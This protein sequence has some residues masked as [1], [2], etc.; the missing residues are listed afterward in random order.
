MIV[1]KIEKISCFS[2]RYLASE[3]SQVCFTSVESD[4]GRRAAGSCFLTLTNVCNNSRWFWPDIRGDRFGSFM[5]DVSKPKA[6]NAS[7]AARQ[8]LLS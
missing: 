8:I 5:Y 2:G 3:A 6:T 4:R 7:V 1:L